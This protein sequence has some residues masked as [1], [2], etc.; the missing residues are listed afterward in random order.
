MDD[1]IQ[2]AIKNHMDKKLNEMD[3]EDSVMIQ[4]I[5]G[6]ECEGCEYF[7]YCSNEKVDTIYRLCKHILNNDEHFDEQIL[8]KVK[9]KWKPIRFHVRTVA[10]PDQPLHT[11]NEN[12]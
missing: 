2:K 11:K 10:D 8:Q 5:D 12:S 4:T 6:V 1:K 3:E 7:E 9:V